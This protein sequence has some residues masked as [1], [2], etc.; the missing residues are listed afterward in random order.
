MILSLWNGRICDHEQNSD[1]CSER[2]QYY[3][4]TRNLSHPIKSSFQKQEGQRRLFRVM[5]FLSES[6][7]A[8]GGKLTSTSFKRLIVAHSPNRFFLVFTRVL[9]S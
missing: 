7:V 5:L 6:R 3:G 9:N 1:F 8:Y 2:V 4:T